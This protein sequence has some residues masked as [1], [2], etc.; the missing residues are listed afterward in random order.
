LEAEDTEG[1]VGVDPTF[2][3]EDPNVLDLN[4]EI[5]D[6]LNDADDGELYFDKGKH[7]PHC[8]LHSLLILSLF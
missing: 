6:G 1:G 7:G 2:I 4:V 5:D 3:E 8:I